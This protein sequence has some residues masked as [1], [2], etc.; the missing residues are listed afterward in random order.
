MII[1]HMSDGTI[2]QNIEGVVI[3]RK[4]DK[5]YELAYKKRIRGENQNGNKDKSSDISKK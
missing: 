3:P 5:I 1:H 4:F 2:R